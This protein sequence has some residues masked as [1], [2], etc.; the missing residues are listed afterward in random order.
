MLSCALVLSL[1]GCQKPAEQA[2]APA[3]ETPSATPAPPAAAAP[4][5]AAAEDPRARLRRFHWRLSDAN[6]GGGQKLAALFTDGEPVQLDFGPNS[7]SIDHLC[8]RMSGDYRLRGDQL[9]FGALASTRM[10]CPDPARTAQEQA[11]TTVFSGGFELA[12]EGDAAAPVLVLKRAN[13]TTLRFAGE[14]TAES[15][16]GAGETVFLEVAAQTKACPHPLI[17][18]KQCLQVREVRFDQEGLRQGEPGPWQNFNED[19]QGYSHQ[20][21]VRNVLRV[22]RYTRPSPPADASSNLYVLDLVVESEQVH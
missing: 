16:Y 4:T 12:F 18:D 21:G 11:A 8:N 20:P 9:E 5:A 15:R 22:K 3:A 17:K 6:D 1:V 7:V 2:A 14:E 13:G 10:A 19:I